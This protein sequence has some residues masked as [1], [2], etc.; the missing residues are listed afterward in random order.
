ML[1]NRE[2]IINPIHIYLCLSRYTCSIAKELILFSLFLSFSLSLL[3]PLLFFIFEVLE[4]HVIFMVGF[5]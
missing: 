3:S 1:P 2:M 5:S 4:D